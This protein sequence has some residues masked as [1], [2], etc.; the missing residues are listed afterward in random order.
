M[1]QM[2]QSS[3][4]NQE[5]GLVNVTSSGRLD[6]H[7]DLFEGLLINNKN[8]WILFFIFWWVLLRI[9]FFRGGF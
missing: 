5:G 3:A 8:L 2:V 1:P 4:V 6:I 9:K 7:K